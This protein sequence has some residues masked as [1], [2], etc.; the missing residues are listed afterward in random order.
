[1]LARIQR[2]KYITHLNIITIFN[3]LRIHLESEDF[4]I[5]VISLEAYKYKVLS[6]DLTND[7]AI[8]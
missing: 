5:F 4:T 6:F 1:M 8:Y 3:K 2:Y 7:S